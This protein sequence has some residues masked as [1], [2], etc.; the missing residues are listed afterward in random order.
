[1]PGW[2]L[3]RGSSGR[4]P[5]ASEIR[6]AKLT[7]REAGALNRLARRIAAGSVFPKDVKRLGG[8]GLCEARLDG[9]RR[10]FRL[11]FAELAADEKVL[12]ALVFTEKKR[13][14]LPQHVLA[15]A[16]RRLQQHLDR[17]REGDLS[18]ISDIQFLGEDT[19]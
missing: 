10:I 15:T 18:Y 19:S 4:S 9:E 6:K 11:L 14:K 1:M 5:V 17:A 12:L 8:D 13:R 16:R 7:P 2:E 3:V